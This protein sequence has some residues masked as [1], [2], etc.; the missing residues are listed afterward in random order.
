EKMSLNVK[1]V[2]R[3]KL[4]VVYANNSESASDMLKV[5][6]ASGAV[7]KMLE[8]KINKERRND[9]NRQFNCDMAN[10]ER[11]ST[12]AARELDAIRIIEK[13]AGLDS[14]KPKL[15]EAAMLRKEN[16]SSTIMEMCALCD[17]P[18]AKSTL[19]N[20]LNKLIEIAK[21]LSD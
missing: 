10:I 19:K 16:E 17:P 18:L 11:A 20:R 4:Y 5:T 12:N 9:T 13:K 21:E 3:K 2:K 7:F 14:L 15:R 6:E 8:A 1:T